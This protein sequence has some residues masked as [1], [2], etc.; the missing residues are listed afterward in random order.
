MVAEMKWLLNTETVNGKKS[1]PLNMNLEFKIG[2]SF[3]FLMKMYTVLCICY[4]SAT[5]AF[6]LL[7]GKKPHEK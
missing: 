2:Y 3:C 5:L 1:T 4:T 7:R 6:S